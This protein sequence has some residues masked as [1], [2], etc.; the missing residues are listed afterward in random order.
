MPST[1]NHDEDLDVEA[2]SRAS[3]VGGRKG[4]K[5]ALKEACEGEEGCEEGLSRSKG[6]WSTVSNTA[7]RPGNWSSDSVTENSLVILI[8]AVSTE[9]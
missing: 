5:T 6:E 9:E 1:Q 7:D 2:E 4:I 8:R 3:E